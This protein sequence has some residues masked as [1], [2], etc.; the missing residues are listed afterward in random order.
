MTRERN[1]DLKLGSKCR[2]SSTIVFDVRTSDLFGVP[3]WF[4]LALIV[5]EGFFVLL[6]LIHFWDIWLVRIIFGGSFND[7]WRNHPCR[8]C[9]ILYLNVQFG[10]TGEEI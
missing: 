5:T 6:G 10:F 4:S 2:R 9:R 7:L 1:N 3:L 8:S